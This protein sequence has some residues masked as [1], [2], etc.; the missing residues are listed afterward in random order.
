[1]EGNKD[2]QLYIGIDLITDF[3]GKKISTRISGC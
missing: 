2:R 3:T 1:M